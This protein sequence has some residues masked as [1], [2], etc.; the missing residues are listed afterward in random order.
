MAK[1]YSIR[2][3]LSNLLGKGSPD[4]P[5]NEPPVSPKPDGESMSGGGA[6]LPSALKWTAMLGYAERYAKMSISNEI[7]TIQLRTGNQKLQ[8]KIQ[9][10]YE[11][12]GRV[13]DVAK[14]AIIGTVMGGGVGT[15]V[16]TAVGATVS[17]TTRLM[18]IQQA[19]RVIQLER[20]IE[21]IGI[22]QSALRIATTTRTGG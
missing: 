6:S 8:Q 11:I 3:F 1:A 12:G 17:A 10:G 14:S 13:F 4:T 7:S 21:N 5:N 20:T 2:I 9:F 16:G 15:L 19:N 18:Q 22:E